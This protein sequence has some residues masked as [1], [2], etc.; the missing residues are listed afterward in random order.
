MTDLLK[1]MRENPEFKAVLEEA[2]RIRPIVPAFNIMKT[3]SEQYMVVENIKY[4]TAMK[5]GFDLLYQYLTGRSLNI[6]NL[7]EISNGRSNADGKP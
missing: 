1:A 5:Q 4:Y 6:V 3:E 7:K 2:L